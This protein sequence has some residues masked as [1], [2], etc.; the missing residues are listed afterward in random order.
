VLSG[1]FVMMALSRLACFLRIAPRWESWAM[2][3]SLTAAAACFLIGRAGWAPAFALSGILGPVFPLL[4]ARMSREFPREA[5]TLTYWIITTVQF[6]LSLCNLGVGY[7]TDRFGI[8]VS[9]WVPAG[10][11]ALTLAV[12]VPYLWDR[13][14]RPGQPAAA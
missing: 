8:R 3:G 12:M 6:T 4:L 11:Y 14:I 9:Y 2:T 1:F 13:R 10:F 5:P 7:L